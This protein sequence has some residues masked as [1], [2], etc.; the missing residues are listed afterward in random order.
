MYEILKTSVQARMIFTFTSTYR[1]SIKF[2][3]ALHN[4]MR[5]YRKTHSFHIPNIDT[6]STMMNTLTGEFYN[7]RKITISNNV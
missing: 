5:P 3:D 2:N 1:L 6:I 4:I 7:C